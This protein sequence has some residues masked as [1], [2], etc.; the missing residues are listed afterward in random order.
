[1]SLIKY[2]N[3]IAHG[4]YSYEKFKYRGTCIDFKELLREGVTC[5]CNASVS[6]LTAVF[7]NR[8]W[9]SRYLRFWAN[10]CMNKFETESKESLQYLFRTGLSFSID[11]IY[12]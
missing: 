9:V 12:S 7:M 1:M 4:M 2:T 11:K 6:K 3:T 5:T 10:L 8:L